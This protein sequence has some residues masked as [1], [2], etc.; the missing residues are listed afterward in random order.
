M[1]GYTH[2]QV[3]RMAGRQLR[4]GVDVERVFSQYDTDST[5]T[6]VRADFVQVALLRRHCNY[7][8]CCYLCKQQQA[9]NYCTAS[10]ASLE[11]KHKQCPETLYA[12]TCANKQAMFECLT[13]VHYDACNHA[14]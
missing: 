4:R 14:T 6:L 7:Y 13:N 11:M 3:R 9:S 1:N 2:A 10:C 12:A 8:C 5:G